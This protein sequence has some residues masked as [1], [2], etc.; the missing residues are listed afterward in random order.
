MNRKEDMVSDF[1]MMNEITSWLKKTV[2]K[3]RR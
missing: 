3:F 2:S 1:F